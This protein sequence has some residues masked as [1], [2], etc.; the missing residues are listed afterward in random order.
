MSTSPGIVVCL[1]HDHGRLPPDT[2]GV[3]AFARRLA[4]LTGLGLEALV[5]GP[6]ARAAAA[7]AAAATGWDATALVCD[8]LEPYNG[9]QFKWLLARHFGG[10]APRWLVMRHGALSQETAPGLALRLGGTCVTGVLDAAGHQDGAALERPV[11]GG[12]LTA[13][14][15]AA[16]SPVVVTVVPTGGDGVAAAVAGRVH[17]VTAD[18]PKVDAVVTGRQA[19]AESGAALSEAA[20]IVAAGNGIGDAAGMTHVSALAARLPRSAVAG[21]R[22]VC[23]S[24]W[25]PHHRQVGMTGA[26]VAPDLYIACG[27]SGAFQHV[28]GMQGAGFV[29]AVNRDPRAPIFQVADV[30]IVADLSTFLPVLIDQLAHEDADET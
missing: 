11:F 12:K 18:L 26:T 6:D 16:A 8:L 20:I 14:V 3:C 29:V 28:A 2:A 19:A 5:A 10:R 27:I 23:D 13:S 4:D 15:V 25:L 24:G 30:G 1:D 21:S 7:A 22:P 17:V 9:E